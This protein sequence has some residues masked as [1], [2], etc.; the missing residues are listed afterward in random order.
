MIVNHV[1]SNNVRSGIFESI[2]GYFKKYSYENI[3]NIVTESPIEEADVYHFHRANLEDQLPS[4]SVVTV[5]HDLKDT[6]AWLDIN[7]FLPK[8]KMS[9]K[10]ICLNSLQKKQLEEF[11]VTNTIVIPHG[12]NSD[13]FTNKEKI[14]NSNGKTRILISSKRYGRRV[15]GEAYLQE[16]LKYIDPNLAEFY[17][18]GEGRLQDRIIFNRFGIQTK[19]YEYLPYSMFGELYRNVDFL[20]MCSY[21]EGGPA[22][23][24]EAVASGTPVICNPI[25]MAHD[26]I[27]NNKNGIYL[28]MNP[29][30]DGDRINEI[31]TNKDKYFSI[32]EYAKSELYRSRAIT[33]KESI[34]R[35]NDVYVEV[36]K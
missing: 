10:V 28:T 18:V 21:F 27:E 17:L 35:N 22:N 25:G 15:K 30:V 5:H 16:L 19:I 36:N 32:L 26:M 14:K 6:D 23:I 29:R 4:R 8:Y 34:Q 7:K 2:L 20:L 13:I 11:G 3:V 33:W 12:Y 31:L 9:E 1:M 24:P